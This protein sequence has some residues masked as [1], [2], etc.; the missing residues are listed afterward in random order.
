MPV[1]YLTLAAVEE[2]SYIVNA[3]FE[4]EDGNAKSPDSVTW[5]LTDKYGTIIN[6]RED[7]SE[8]PGTSIDMVLYGDDLQI[9]SYVSYLD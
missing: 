8:T 2:S 3:A 6:S 7:V 5:T 9:L 1:A 4:D